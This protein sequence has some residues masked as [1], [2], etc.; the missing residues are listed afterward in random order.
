MTSKPTGTM[1][2]TTGDAEAELTAAGDCWAAQ[3]EWQ[4]YMTRAAEQIS[5]AGLG[6][7]PGF[8]G[9]QAWLTRNVRAADG[10][11]VWSVRWRV[12]GKQVC[13]PTVLVGQFVTDCIP[14][15]HRVTGQRKAVPTHGRLVRVATGGTHQR[16]H[17]NLREVRVLV[18]ALG[19][20]VPVPVEVWNAQFA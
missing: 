19:L 2:S 10:L 5:T 15:E 20:P 9:G 1:R 17:D 12:H 18:D 16:R 14:P 13:G 8:D 7:L 6:L 3:P 4:D 11:V